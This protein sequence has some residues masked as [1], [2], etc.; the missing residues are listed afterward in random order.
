MN[1]FKTLI[2]YI[3]LLTLT[4]C[5]GSTNTTYTGGSGG[6]GTS[7]SE[8][9]KPEKPDS[10]KP[11]TPDPEPPKPETPDPET[12]K[13]P[14]TPDAVINKTQSKWDGPFPM[15][16]VAS[17]AAILPDGQILTWSAYA[18]LQF[19]YG[20]TGNGQTFTAIF[21]PET[22]TFAN[23]FVNDTN[24]D[25]FCPGTAILPDG[26]IM[27]TGGSSDRQTSIFDPQK[28]EW[29]KGA[30]MNIRRAYHS[31]TPL[32]DGSI[33]T[34]GGS[35]GYDKT[36]P[37]TMKLGGK[38]GE[39]WSPVSQKWKNKPGIPGNVFATDDK[40]GLYRADNHL[41]MFTAPNGLVFQA[42]PAKQMHWIDT[43]GQGKVTKS[44]LRGSDNDAMSGNAVMY[45][46]G[47]L[48]AVGGAPD[49]DKSFAGS[50][51]HV[52]DI[53]KGLNQVSVRK[54]DSMKHKRAFSN[55]VVLPSGEVVVIG[56]QT[57]AEIFTDTG[58][59]MAAE[60]WDPKTEKFTTLAKMKVP[61]NY[62]SIA[63]LMKDG[64][65]FAA[66]GGLCGNNCPKNGGNHPDAEIFTPPYL[67]TTAGTPS[68]RPKLLTAPST[69]KAGDKM[70]VT[71]DTSS[72][73]SFVLIRTSAVTHAVNN[74]ERRIPLKMVD[75]DLSK[76]KFTLK[77]PDNS[78]V[79]LPG[80]Y[81]L[82]ALNK[83]GVPSIAKVI[84][85]GGF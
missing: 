32:S 77:I 50:D 67:L 41:W 78:A 5:G 82:F 18:R 58:S 85:I 59:A 40:K 64:R 55:S 76:G 83:N 33:L 37:N 35:W 26:R 24:H 3:S 60:I 10:P 63:L 72:E 8:A 65:I 57:F 12:P 6:T 49:Y 38:N 9:S 74:D 36:N 25:M 19:H 66:G 81:F 80:T 47:K 70:A 13:L 45:D 4:A 11:E 31:M 17:A 7:D 75:K 28:G 29:Q 34:I 27:V 2:F 61:R 69:A 42:G 43:K 56:G 14:K 23:G 62:H 20:D 84:K 53:S 39:V 46:I 1:H 48:L 79:V 30:K 22:E 16:L 51:A 71:V 68:I 52:I 21:D 15:S 73:H 44:L 54:V